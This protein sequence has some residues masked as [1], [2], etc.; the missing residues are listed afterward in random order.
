[1]AAKVGVSFQT[2]PD[3]WLNAQKAVDLHE[4]RSRLRRL[5]KPLAAT[6]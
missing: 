1:M 3:F 5:P 2:S 4:A 6:N